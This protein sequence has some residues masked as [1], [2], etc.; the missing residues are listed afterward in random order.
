MRLAWLLASI[1]AVANAFA[2]PAAPSYDAELDGYTYPFP[3]AFFAF[4]SQR[5]TLKMAYLDVKPDKPNGRTVLLLHGKNFNAAYWEPTIREL[6]ARGYRVVAP[7]QIGFGKS[8]KPAAYQFSFAA[9]ADDTRALLDSI[10]VDKVAVVGH[11]MGGMLAVRFSLL[12]P[13]R[14]TRLGLV[15]PI[16]LEDY[17]ALVP[18]R[19]ID[20]LFANELKATPESL[21]NYQ[22]ENYFHGEWK[23]EYEP[24]VAPLIG[25]RQHADYPKV[26]WDSALT[27]EMVMTQPV[28]HDFPRL[29]LPV[30]LIIGDKDRSA[31][32][33]AWATKEV[34]ASLGNYPVLGR[35]AVK[36]I[37]GA[38]LVELPGVGHLPQV[39][40]FPA[41]RD[42]LVGFLGE[43]GR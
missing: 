3:V 5:Q 4:E 7:D 13:E 42:A 38:R 12:Y 34:G 27:T 35:R 18:Y 15:D 26:A 25:W 2:A 40:A 29:K 33:R 19:P 22:K 20:Q 8:S 36:A 6:T 28:V 17:G 39:E 16:G 9:L 37:P 31:P 41:Y 11:S 14:V 32:G 1:L 23:P 24:L 43:G 10:G 21:R 30:L